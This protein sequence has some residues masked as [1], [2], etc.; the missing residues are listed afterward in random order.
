MSPDILIQI[1]PSTPPNTKVHYNKIWH[2]LLN[3]PSQIHLTNTAPPFPNYTFALPLKYPPQY[4]YYID[5][6]FFPPKQISPNNWRPKMASYG[7][8]SP[9]KNLQISERLPDLQNILTEKLMAI[10]TIIRHILNNFADEPVFIFTDSLNSLYVLNTQ[11]KHPSMH[12]NHPDKTI[13]TQIVQILQSQT[14]PTSLYKV[15]AHSNI[16]GN[17][18]VD[19]LAKNGRHKPHSLPSKAHE[20]AYSIPYYFHKDE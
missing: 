19:T 20:F 18:I 1:T 15:K 3:P 16:T 14:Q 2:T 6:S 8:F 12:N 4:N 11:I 5:G 9:I 10:Y 17:E 7:V 13:L